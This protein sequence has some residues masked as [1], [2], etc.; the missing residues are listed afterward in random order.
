MSED[1]LAAM[2]R[3]SR[4]RVARERE[5]QPQRELQARARELPAAPRLAL[6]NSGFD[7]IAEVKLRSPA[8][9]QLKAGGEDITARVLAYADAG[10]AA[11]S[12]LTEPSRFDGALSHLS[13]AASSLAGRIPVMRKDFLVD[14][15]QVYQARLAGAGG[16]L[17]ILRMLA[18]A[19][20]EA[21]I[22]AASG[23]GLFA[24]LEAFDAADLRL[25]ADLVREYGPR[26]TLL[27]GVNCRDLVTLEVVPGRL[28]ALAPLLPRSVP[29]VAES[30]V[31]GG[32]DAARLVAEGYDVA[33]VGSALMQAGDPLVLA[34]ALLAAGRAAASARV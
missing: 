5:L 19:E 18:R 14:A 34:R 31:T 24:L 33:L 13:Q 29:R 32:S 11:I 10:A 30:G 26:T 4:E 21:L 7:L 9:G 1:F 8:S 22:E 6:S 16:V 17:I 27:V 25:A 23:L 20:L 28:E 15:Y 3:S 2:A 12:V